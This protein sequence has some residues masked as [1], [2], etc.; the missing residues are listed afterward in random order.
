MACHI[1][2]L[3]LLYLFFSILLINKSTKHP[4]NC[5]YLYKITKSNLL[6]HRNI[7][8]SQRQDSH[9]ESCLQRLQ[10]VHSPQSNSAQTFCLILTKKNYKSRT[11]AGLKL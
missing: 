8:Q 9:L 3:N 2:H 1:Y 11:Q 4:L 7:Q 6:K 5:H 10:R